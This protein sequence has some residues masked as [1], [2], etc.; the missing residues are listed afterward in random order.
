MESL[1]NNEQIFS[2]S[3][4]YTILKQTITI[5]C[6][7]VEKKK[8]LHNISN[9]SPSFPGLTVNIL[10]WVRNSKVGTASFGMADDRLQYI[11]TV[12]FYAKKLTITRMICGSL[13]TIGTANLKAL[14]TC[15]GHFPRCSTYDFS[16]PPS[17]FKLWII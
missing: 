1:T 3:S 10:R 16:W 11:I 2:I 13:R 4:F 12:F 14:F 6:L 17:N 7:F 9:F 5:F 8:W 15:Y